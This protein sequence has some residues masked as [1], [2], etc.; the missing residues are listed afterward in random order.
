MNATTPSM[1]GSWRRSA[2]RVGGSMRLMELGITVKDRILLHLLDYWGHMPRG[3][4]PPELTQDGIASV[5]GISRSHVAVTLPDLVESG[6]VET[7]VD[8]VKGRSRRVKIYHLTYQGGQE[9]GSLAQRIL[10]STV[11]AVDDSGEWDLPVDGLIQLHRVHML[12]A[13]RLVD[14]DNS[15]DLRRAQELIEV[16]EVKEERPPEKAEAEAEAEEW[17]GEEAV[18]VDEVGTGAVASASLDLKAAEGPMAVRQ[19]TSRTPSGMMP[20]PGHGPEQGPAQPPPQVQGQAWAGQAQY[21]PPRVWSPLRFGTG[22]RPHPSSVSSLLMLGFITVMVAVTL[23]GIWPV[24]CMAAWIPLAVFG[25][26][27]SYMGFRSLWALG[28][29]REAWT[30]TAFAA[31]TLVPV[32]LASFAFFGPEVFFD[33]GWAL[34]ILG[35][36]SLVLMAGTGQSVARRGRFALF[37]G[38]VV[39]IAAVT[40]GVLDPGGLGRTGALPLLMVVA[41]AGWTFVGWVMTRPMEGARPMGSVVAGGCIGLAIAAISG[42]AKLASEGQMDPLLT[43]A[44][45]L[46][47]VLAVYVAATVLLPSMADLMPDV[48]AGYVVLAVGGAAS[49]LTTAAIFIYGNVAVMGAMEVL[50]AIALLAM[51]A[52]EMKGIGKGGAILAWLGS[53]VAV[54]TVMAFLM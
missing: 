25:G 9:A 26:M 23:F 39:V 27:F 46:W 48:R 28:P 13:L 37:I 21:Y 38:P 8:R 35:V 16:P 7:V 12:V 24:T 41:G 3:E 20:S 36:P 52:P 6:Q 10:A 11:T 30:A 53:M 49:L 54:T 5:V 33:L 31:F 32:S 51:V 29:A 22:R 50:I 43:M 47:V 40:L 1:V 34:L 14:E 19:P 15:V 17:E 4:W 18:T 42:G 2:A 45:A 44:V